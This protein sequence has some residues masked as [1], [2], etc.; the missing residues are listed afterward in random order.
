VRLKGSKVAEI[1]SEQGVPIQ[2]PG[3]RSEERPELECA[4][5]ATIDPW[6]GKPLILLARKP[7]PD[8]SELSARPHKDV[9]RDHL[10]FGEHATGFVGRELARKAGFHA[11][12]FAKVEK[13]VVAAHRIFNEYD[14][15]WVEF[16]PVIKTRD[17]FKV[18]KATI[19]VDERALFRHPDIESSVEPH[20]PP[21]GTEREKAARTMGVLYHD[22]DGDIGILPGGTGI[23]LAVVDL[24]RN[25]GGAPADLLDSG[26]DASPP[27]LKQM[28]DLLMDNPK[29]SVVLC[30]RYG[31]LSRCDDWA[32]A[33]IPYIIDNRTAKPMVLRL[34]G[35]N[36]DEARRLFDEAV[37]QNP[38][39]FYKVRI[40]YSNTAVDNV[41]REA[42]ALAEALKKGE[43]PYAPEGVS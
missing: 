20:P 41:I 23:G 11:S 30:C 8:W 28:L 26:G 1:V 22:L 4:L 38:E 6:A 17:G 24:V 10:E 12:D 33:I 3:D 21:E 7:V 42:V 19:D 36:E 32:R 27:H 14:C 25:V 5:I 18:L 16:N 39:A 31:G 34:A 35:N 15:V 37:R 29:V 2:G 43:D 9:A 40:F 13:L